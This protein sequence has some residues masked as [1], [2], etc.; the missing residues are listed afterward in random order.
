MAFVSLP[1]LENPPAG[2][3]LHL[4]VQGGRLLAR[5]GADRSVLLPSCAD[6]KDTP[7]SLALGLLD[8]RPCWSSET[9]ADLAA[10]RPG[11]DWIE[12][13]P[14]LA[15]LPA[16]ALHAVCAARELHWWRSQTRFC[17]RC[18]GETIDVDTERARK[19]PRCGAMFFPG[20]SPAVIVAVLRDDQLLLA[21]N[22][23]FSPGLFSLIAG[24]VD[25]GETLE[26]AAAREVRE[27]TGL[28][29]RNLAYL[30]S[31]PWPFPNS[32]MLAFRAEY[33]GGVVTADGVEIESAA[34]FRR[35][36]LPE[37]PTPG[38]VARRLVD[39]WLAG[40]LQ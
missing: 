15:V 37:L 20:A 2:S 27:E 29:I 21:H 33:A 6:L 12:T 30:T 10:P 28:E 34:W 24:F 32:L 38:T 8:G 13:R 5:L 26:Q 25:P 31:Q 7:P 1:R 18:G 14:L 3:D 23:K 22:R 4:V 19:C 39:A 16:S 40:R 11:W 9:P 17:G 35:D 36:R